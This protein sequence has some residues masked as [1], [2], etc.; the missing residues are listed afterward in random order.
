MQYASVWNRFVAVFIDF[1]LL[2]F[3]S[4]VFVQAA[5]DAAAVAILVALFAYYIALEAVCGGTVG[6]LLV[7]LRVVSDDGSAIT[8]RQAFLRNLVRPIDALFVYVVA[9]ISIALSPKEQRL[10]DRLAGT[11]V[12]KRVLAVA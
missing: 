5:G 4:F 1:V 8:W 3:A 12:V 10:G 11:L 2:S 7:G 9:L 6:K